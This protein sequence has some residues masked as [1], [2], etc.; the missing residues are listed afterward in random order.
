MWTTCSL[1]WGVR[2]NVLPAELLPPRMMGLRFASSNS[3]NARD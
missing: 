2:S 3:F 1:I